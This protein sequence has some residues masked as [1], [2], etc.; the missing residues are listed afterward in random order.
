MLFQIDTGEYV[1]LPVRLLR[2]PAKSDEGD[3]P[4]ETSWRLIWLTFLPLKVYGYNNRRL[5]IGTD[6]DQ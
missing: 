5:A 2:N 6:L 4:K 1:P 3:A